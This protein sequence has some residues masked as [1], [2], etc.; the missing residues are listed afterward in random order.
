MRRTKKYPVPY[1]NR[2]GLRS[3]D[4]MASAVQRAAERKQISASEYACQAVMKE[5]QADGESNSQN[6][7]SM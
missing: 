5:L 1:I 7:T 2:I 4:A 3:S 6:T